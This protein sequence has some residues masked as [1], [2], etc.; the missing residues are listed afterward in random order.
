[1]VSRCLCGVAILVVCGGV[2]VAEGLGGTSDSQSETAKFDPAKWSLV[3]AEE[4][5]REGTPDPAV[6][7]PELGYLRN[8]EA[9]YYTRRSENA[10]VEKGVLVIEART[11]DWEGKPITSASLTTKGTRSFRYGRIEV[12]AKIPT[13]RGTWPAIWLLGED[14][15]GGG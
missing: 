4:F 2:A 9:Q 10:R 6:W 13:G 15:S 5:E 1:M 3:W 8:K 7:K 11:D 14:K 12:R